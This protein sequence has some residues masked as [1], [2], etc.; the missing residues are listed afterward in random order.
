MSGG[1]FNFLTGGS[2]AA[3]TLM[4]NQSS[5]AEIDRWI[6]SFLLDNLHQIEENGLFNGKTG[7]MALLYEQGYKDIV[8]NELKMLKGTIKKTD[9]SLR[10][11]LSGIGLF[12]ISL[13]FE[14]ENIEYLNLAK[15]LEKFIEI[16][17]LK[18]EPLKVTDWMAVDIGVIDGLS[19]VSLFYSALFSEDL[20]S[21]K[22]DDV[23]GILQT[24]DNRNRLLPYLS[25]GSIG[26]AI[27][28][29]FFNHV[30]GQDLYRQ[31]MDAILK[32]SNY[33][34]QLVGVCLMVQEVFC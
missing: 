27:S 19:V 16:N 20:K 5:T 7:I 30:S 4:K 26:V 22:I 1:K 3:F 31:E 32:T 12:V 2:G 6:K 24:L 25:G 23:S 29:W 11:G 28:I 8:L 13:Y 34:V 21:I 10:S 9:I 17:R 33:I 15:E 14:T 18:E